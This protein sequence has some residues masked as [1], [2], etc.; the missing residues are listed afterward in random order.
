MP[1][2]QSSRRVKVLKE[3][4]YDHV[5]DLVDHDSPPPSLRPISADG[6]TTGT[7]ASS[8]PVSSSLSTG[9]SKG[10]GVRTENGRTAGA[11]P[12]D[13]SLDPGRYTHKRGPSIEIQGENPMKH[14][15]PFHQVHC[16]PRHPRPDSNR[17]HLQ[18]PPPAPCPKYPPATA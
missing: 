11:G 10:K 13:A 4:D 1:R 6:V 14:Q 16:P 18:S 3:G 9:S 2:L 15:F 5:I 17:V 8:R 12:A 7:G